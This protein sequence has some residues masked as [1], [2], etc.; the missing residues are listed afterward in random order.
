[1]Y[2]YISIDDKPEG[3]FLIELFSDIVPKTCA[4]FK[5]IS[6]GHVTATER[7][8]TYEKT[9]FHRLVPNGWIQGGDIIRGNGSD[10]RSI[11]GDTFEDENFAILHNKRGIL[12]MAN[13]GRHTNNSQF[14]ITLTATPWMNC[15]Y[16]AFGQ[17]LEG[18]E[19]LEKME[20]Q[21]TIN[22]HPINNI[23]ITKCVMLDFE[24][25]IDD[26]IPD[27]SIGLEDTSS[28]A[29]E[30]ETQVNDENVSTENEQ[31]Q[32]GGSQNEVQ[33]ESTQESSSENLSAKKEIIQDDE[34]N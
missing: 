1:M 13:H 29:D 21:K 16:V 28:N 9:I 20:E 25:D 7:L 26:N 32:N 4:N 23:V 24:E 10:G 8:L 11:Y 14:Y 31:I 27:F 5:A 3:H 18:T 2:M 33:K 12:G 17:L 6:M 19:L 22:E 30:D 34:I 15:R